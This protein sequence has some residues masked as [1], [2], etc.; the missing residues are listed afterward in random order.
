MSIFFYYIFVSLF[1]T[2][3]TS[4][5]FAPQ[6]IKI[7]SLPLS[8]FI[9]TEDYDFIFTNIFEVFT[10]Y[11]TLAFYGTIFLNFP[12]FLYFLYLFVRPGLFKYE[13]NLLTFMYKIFILFVLF[14][15]FFTYYLILPFML[16]FLLDFDLITNSSFIVLRM[17][18][19]I[20]DYVIFFCNLTFLYCFFIFQIPTLFIIFVYFKQ[21]NILFFYKKRR[22][23][24]VTSFIIGCLF[25]SPDLISLFIVSFPFIFFFE[26]VVFICILKNNYENNL[27]LNIVESCLNGK[28]QVC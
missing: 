23:F 9:K 25:S 13:K 1:L 16:S 20:Y 5:F 19:R 4:Y 22:V 8:K 17:E 7:L 24:I 3:V 28:R 6:L 12:L 10:T 26:C 11:V 18:T 2:F 14:S 15:V 21:P 27:Y